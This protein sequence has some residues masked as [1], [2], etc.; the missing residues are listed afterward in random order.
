MTLYYNCMVLS[1]RNIIHLNCSFLNVHVDS[2]FFLSLPGFH[3]DDLQVKAAK[4]HASALSE[5]TNCNYRSIWSMYHKFTWFYNL[6]PFPARVETVKFYNA[7]QF[8]C[9][10]PRSELVRFFHLWWYQG[11]AHTQRPGKILKHHFSLHKLPTTPDML[12]KF[13]SHLDFRIS[14]YLAL[15]AALLVGF[16]TFLEQLTYA[17]RPEKLFPPSPPRHVIT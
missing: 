4:V 8:L 3:Y 2:V 10:V 11:E 13:H 14:A 17:P 6:E 15:W 1:L 7:A 16:F 5:G 12:L 9:Q